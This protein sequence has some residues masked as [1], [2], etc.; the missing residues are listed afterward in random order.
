[1]Y[2][3]DGLQVFMHENGPINSHRGNE[4]FSE[5]PTGAHGLM[6]D[7]SAHF[8]SEDLDLYILG[9]LCTRANGE[10]V[11]AEEWQ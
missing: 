3:A 10:M 7:G 8:F 4:W 1:V 6:A 11:N 2:W 5:H 9:A